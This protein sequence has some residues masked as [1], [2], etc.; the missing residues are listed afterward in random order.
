MAA[1]DSKKHNTIIVE[2][3][4][5]GDLD[6]KLAETALDSSI[7]A[8]LSVRKYGAEEVFRDVDINTLAQSLS[9]QIKATKEND[10]DD[11]EAMLTG[12]AYVLNAMFNNLTQKAVNNM[13]YDMRV[14]EAFLKYGLRV[15]SQ[16]QSTIEKIS[17]I[18]N[19][20]LVGYARQANIAHGHQQVNNGL[21]NQNVQN[22]L[23]EEKDG[24][25]LDTRAKSKAGRDDP[26]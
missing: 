2:E 12:Q 7:Q 21:E 3:P 10:L 15:Q 22:E 18:K 23:L 19:P 5:D 14:A 8:S 17:Q 11:L 9:E 25:W 16:C 26:Q 6:K 20:P 1:N 4:K 24:E 13:G